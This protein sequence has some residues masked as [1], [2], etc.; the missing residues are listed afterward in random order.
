MD[1]ELAEAL[2]FALRYDGRTRV[3]HADSMMARIAA[4]RPVRHL[5][6]WSSR[7]LS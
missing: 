4:E 7:V 3:H 2:A 1:D 5:E 6:Q